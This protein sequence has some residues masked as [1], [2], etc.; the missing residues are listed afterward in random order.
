[1]TEPKAWGEHDVRQ[2]ASGYELSDAAVAEIMAVSFG[3]DER[4]WNSP[5][6]S[7]Y[8]EGA[9]MSK[10]EI[11]ISI[12]IETNGAAPG[13]HSM[14]SLG[15]WAIMPSDKAGESYWDGPTFYQNL[16]PLPDATASED[17]MAWWEGF[18]DAYREATSHQREPIDVMAGFG[19]WCEEVGEHGR[20]VAAAWPAAFD[21]SFVNWYMHKFVGSNPLGFSCLD[22]RS[23]ANGLFRVPGYYDTR[24]GT[25]EGDLYKHFGIRT[26]DLNPHK[27][28]DDAIRQ[29]RLL[30]ALLKEAQ[31]RKAAIG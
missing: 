5:E 22:I 7:V 16:F 20:L 27:A 17:T 19:D 2:T 18:P 1:M 15:A 30:I 12:D 4:D 21:F 9:N 10:Q 28:D 6:D 23:F 3:P 31:N 8:D 26:D 24:A 11:Y 14:L 25:T 13:V 29:G